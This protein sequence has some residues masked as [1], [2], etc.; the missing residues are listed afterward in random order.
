MSQ[1]AADVLSPDGPEWARRGAACRRP[2][3]ACARPGSGS[4][5]WTLPVTTPTGA[6]SSPGPTG[7]C[8]SHATRRL[9]QPSRDYRRPIE[10]WPRRTDGPAREAVAGENIRGLALRELGPEAQLRAPKPQA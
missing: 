1:S 3:R 2:N 5:R 8:G 7:T 4:G 10:H 9:T 6:T